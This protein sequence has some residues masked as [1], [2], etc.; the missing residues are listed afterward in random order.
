MVVTL[1]EILPQARKRKYAVGAFNT[2]NLEITQAILGAAEKL[3]SPVI[4]AT[5]EKA[6]RYAGIEN[7]SSMV[8][9]MAAATK[10]PVALHL[11]HGKSYDRGLGR[12]SLAFG[13][14][15][16]DLE[17]GRIGGRSTVDI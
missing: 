12:L 7:I 11:D 4:I 2:S 15:P 1:N 10:I 8:I 6:I 16:G 14:D 17:D 3:R 9:T 5:S 13:H